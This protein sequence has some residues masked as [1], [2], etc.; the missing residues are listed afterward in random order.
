LI[1]ALPLAQ[2]KI[3]DIKIVI[4]GAGAAGIAI[5]KL[6]SSYGANNIVLLDSQGATCSVRQ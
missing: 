1:N 2:K 5:T 4:A 3:A 6:L